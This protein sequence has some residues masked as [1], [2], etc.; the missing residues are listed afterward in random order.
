MLGQV[1]S[2][3]P[4]RRAR[5]WVH[6]QVGLHEVV[7]GLGTERARH[8][9]E[10]VAQ[11]VVEPREIGVRVHRQPIDGRQSAVAT[12]ERGELRALRIA[13]CREG[14]LDAAQAP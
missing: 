6:H 10:V 13:L 4:Q 5:R 2:G 14:R 1:R 7:E 9:A 3:V 11:A 8:R 12:D